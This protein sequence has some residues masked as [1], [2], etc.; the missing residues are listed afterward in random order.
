LL[1]L[2]SGLVCSMNRYVAGIPPLY[3]VLEEE[4][5]RPRLYVPVLVLSLAA[6]LALMLQFSTGTGIV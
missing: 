6:Q 2:S 4:L 1:P 5:A 3:P